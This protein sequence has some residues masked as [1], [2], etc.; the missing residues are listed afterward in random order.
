M[1]IDSVRNRYADAVA[2]I[3]VAKYQINL[4]RHRH[5]K[6]RSGLSE[7]RARRAD[8]QKLLDRFPCFAD[9]APDA[10]IPPQRTAQLLRKHIEVD[11]HSAVQPVGTE[12][13]PPCA[14]QVSLQAE[15]D[16]ALAQAKPALDSCLVKT[17][18][19][20]IVMGAAVVLLHPFLL[21]VAHDVSVHLHALNAQRV[22]GGIA[23]VA[24]FAIRHAAA[25]LFVGKPEEQTAGDG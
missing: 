3:A 19:L 1:E 8:A 21:V 9:A 14:E 2:D 4:S 10:G 12:H 18:A 20:D 23:L 24:L 5:S 25:I 6:S 16:R 7:R 17:L 11:E 15:D 22:V 13:S